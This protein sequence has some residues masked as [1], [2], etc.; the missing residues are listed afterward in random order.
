MRSELKEIETVEGYGAERVV[1]HIEVEDD[2][3]N[4][5]P[6]FQWVI[7]KFGLEIVED[8]EK[9]KYQM[10]CAVEEALKYMKRN[11][12][13]NDSSKVK[14]QRIKPVKALKDKMNV[15]VKDIED[16]NKIEPIIEK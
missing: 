5:M 8:E 12:V 15:S 14:K 7:R 13:G 6:D 11:V 2:N 10:V 1:L 4:I 9:L 16:K 3:G